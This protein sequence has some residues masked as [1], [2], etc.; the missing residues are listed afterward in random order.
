[1]VF[2]YSSPSILR[3]IISFCKPRLSG[4]QGHHSLLSDAK[5]GPHPLM[6]LCFWVPEC[7]RDMVFYHVEPASWPKPQMTKCEDS[8]WRIRGR[9]WPKSRN[10]EMSQ[11]TVHPIGLCQLQIQ[12]LTGGT[13]SSCTG[14]SQA[15]D[16]TAACL[17]L[18]FPVSSSSNPGW[19]TSHV[20]PLCAISIKLDWT[21]LNEEC[22]KESYLGTTSWPLPG[23]YSLLGAGSS[24][25]FFLMR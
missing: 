8:V 23:L 13:K 15:K 17:A 2:C 5:P 18:W 22:T 11:V 20:F 19:H 6:P 16:F 4:S 3:I 25:Q 1:M 21:A 14:D 7:G 24:F 10:K 12:R 9:N